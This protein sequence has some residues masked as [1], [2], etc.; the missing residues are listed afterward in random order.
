MYLEQKRIGGA[1]YYY[2]KVSVRYGSKVRTKTVAYLGKEKPAR[3]ALAQTVE[4]YREKA[5]RISA[6]TLQ[7][8]RGET[9]ALARGFLT[10]V[11]WEKVAQLTRDFKAK[12]S[13]LDGKTRAEMFTDF[14]TIYTYNT[15]AIE[16]N[17]F[18]LR[19]TD[20][21]LNKG[22]TPE[23]KSLREVHDQ[24]NTKRVFEHLLR[25]KPAVT[26][27][28]IIELHAL[29]MQGIDARVGGYRAHN[30]RVFGATF[31]TS[32][33]Q[34]VKAD[35]DL[36]LRWYT[37]AGKNLHPLI[38]AAVFHHQFERIHPFYDGNGR[39]GRVL[40]N[41]ILLRNALPPIVVAN[42]QRKRYY[43]ALAKAD[44][45]PLCKID[46]PYGEIVSFCFF[47]MLKTYNTIFGKWG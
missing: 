6:E 5:N 47:S 39:T 29:L 17:T 28:T 37:Q 11:Q 40:L 8:L 33:A 23:G 1:T 14:I 22:I 26:Q 9:T 2:L 25:K 42:D 38:T 13:Q 10:A 31:D 46:L 3:A 44:R 7:E 36:L 34:Y 24:L 30:V 15:N 32:P 21:L 45:V 16:G 18:T 35:M 4:R 20:F 19:D 27:K 43:E 41:L 12:L